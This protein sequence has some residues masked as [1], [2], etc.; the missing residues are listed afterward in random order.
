[1]LRT[2]NNLDGKVD[3]QLEQQR[4]TRYYL[5]KST[6]ARIVE[7]IIYFGRQCLPLQNHREDSTPD[8]TSTE[9]ESSNINSF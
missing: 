7:Y 2:C 8:P 4:Q 3:I 9:G 1:M 5:E 6:L